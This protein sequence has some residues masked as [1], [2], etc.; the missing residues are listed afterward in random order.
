M[1]LQCEQ[2]S[3]NHQ[4][5]F[6]FEYRRYV[7]FAPNSDRC[8]GHRSHGITLSIEQACCARAIGVTVTTFSGGLDGTAFCRLEPKRTSLDC[9]GTSA[10][11]QFTT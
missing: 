5:M 9:I 8:N 10:P 4:Q 6:G 2:S 7:G 1:L 11:R 3:E